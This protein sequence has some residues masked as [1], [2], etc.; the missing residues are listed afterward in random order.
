MRR[1]GQ[2]DGDGVPVL[3]LDQLARPNVVEHDI[4]L[5]RRDF[6]KGDNNNPQP[7]LIRDILAASSDG[8]TLTVAD[9][10]K[11]RK[12]RLACQRRE[13]PELHF[14]AMQNQFAYAEVALILEVF[15][16]GK[17]V[18][19][20]FVKALFEEE[21]LPREEGWKRRGWWSLRFV[22]LNLLAMKVKGLVGGF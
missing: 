16:N 7:D 12:A 18:L 19:L 10:V 15:R 3:D 9:F 11:L 6:A 1:P 8:K 13:N 17:E 4:S 22:E 21:R 14:E 2:K 5:F 20:R